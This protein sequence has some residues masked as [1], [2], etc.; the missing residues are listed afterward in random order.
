MGNGSL[1]PP[2]PPAVP[3]DLTRATARYKRHAWLAVAGLLAFVGLYVSL[4]GWFCWTAFR[5]FRDLFR[6]GED[7]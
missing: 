5:L 1:L 7:A 2:P 4:T 6:G 3:A